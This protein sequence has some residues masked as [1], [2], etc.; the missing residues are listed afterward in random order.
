MTPEA[1]LVHNDNIRKNHLGKTKLSSEQIQ[2]IIRKV[3]DGISIKEIMLEFGI[4][5]ST[6]KAYLK[7][8]L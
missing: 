1:Y 8:Y 7:R 5:H 2:E 3:N 6:I 4:S